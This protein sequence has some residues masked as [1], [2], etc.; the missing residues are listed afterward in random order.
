MHLLAQHAHTA[1]DILHGEISSEACT[2]WHS[3]HIA[4]DILHGEISSEACTC[5]HSMHIAVDIS[6][7][8]DDRAMYSLF[9]S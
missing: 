3:M 8:S 5:W 9:T 1:V 7:I 2:C 6:L 4:V